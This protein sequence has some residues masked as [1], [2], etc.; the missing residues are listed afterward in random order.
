[1]K[2]RARKGGGWRRCKK[3]KK[4]KKKKINIFHK[5]DYDPSV[6]LTFAPVQA[7]ILKA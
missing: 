7:R 5:Y 4:R 6:L 1:V 3:K 2:E